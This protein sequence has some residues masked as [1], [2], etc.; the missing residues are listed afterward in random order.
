MVNKAAPGD[1]GEISN[2]EKRK[3]IEAWFAD[4][5]QQLRTNVF[6]ICGRRDD[7][8]EKW[9]K[10]LLPYFIEGFLKRD[11]NR[12]WEIFTD[13]KF[14]NYC[15]RGMNL[16]LKSKT[17][18]FYHQYRKK[19]MAFRELIPTV[20]YQV[21]NEDNSTKQDIKIKTVKDAIEELDFY[22]RYLIGA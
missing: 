15:T 10:D 22:D 5:Y 12:Q 6:K 2:K 14:E 16:A 1:T 20:N 4:N 18:T 7:I 21:Y 19:G 13:G 9:G 3:I 11:I 17:S 8:V